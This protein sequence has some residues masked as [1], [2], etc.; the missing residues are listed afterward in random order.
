MSAATAIGRFLPRFRLHYGVLL[1]CML[2]EC[3]VQEARPEE[4]TPGN[5][6]T[7]HN[8]LNSGRVMAT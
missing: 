4:L 1:V 5:A 2:A 3:M 7:R 8:L 6:V